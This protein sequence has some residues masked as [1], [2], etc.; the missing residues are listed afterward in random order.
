MESRTDIP[1]LSLEQLDLLSKLRNET[2][3]GLMDCKRALVHSDW[4]IYEAYT[5]LKNYSKRL[6]ITYKYTDE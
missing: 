4:N 5:W 3:F 2:G 1:T 6:L